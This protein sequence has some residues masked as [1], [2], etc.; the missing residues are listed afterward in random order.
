MNCNGRNFDVG[1][2]FWS[3]VE[4]RSE[5]MSTAALQT[6]VSVLGASL[7]VSK[8]L[9]QQ[10]GH[11]DKI[12]RCSHPPSSQLGSVSSS[13]AC[14]PKTAHGLHPTKDL[15]DPFSNPLTEGIAFMTR[16]SPIDGRSAFA[17]G[18]GR[19]MREN[20]SPTQK[21]HKVLRV[22]TLIGSQAFHPNSF[23]S[24]TLKQSLCGFSLCAARGL[25]DF[26]IDQQPVS[27]LHQGMGPITQL[28]LFARPL[29]HQTTVGIGSGLMSLVAAFLTMKIHPTVARISW[30]FIP[31]PI[32]SFS[33]K[34]LK[35]GPGLDQSP[36]DC[37]MIVA[38][39]P[40]P[41][42]LSDYGFKKHSPHLVRHQPL[43]VLAEYRGVNTLFLK[44]HVQ[45]PAKQKSVTQLLA[46]L[47]LAPDRVKRDQQQRLQ[48]LLRCH[49]GPSHLG[50][51]PVKDL[52]Q[53][54]KL[55]IRHR[56]DQ[57]QWMVAWNTGLDR[58]Q[59]QH[60]CLSVLSPAHQRLRKYLRCHI[61]I[62]GHFQSGK[63]FP[64]RSFSAT[65]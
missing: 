28:G 17:L 41:S 24:L 61:N 18:V 23:S 47:P 64:T 65:C 35:A 30:S 26:E 42:S 46:K 37:K 53:S 49:R 15:F 19:H 45:K 5:T 6:H 34:T 51:H 38:H 48:Y 3:V 22:I 63:N 33:S 25:T 4:H 44:L 7:L 29:T 55:L 59:R 1:G 11:A 40:G 16:G 27:I 10:L 32:F 62:D 14:F 12:I 58:K 2:N 50:I 13:E 52:R 21:T 60:T 8:R 9:G 20:L 31:R 54:R 36:I 39:Q 56:F 43:T 57:S